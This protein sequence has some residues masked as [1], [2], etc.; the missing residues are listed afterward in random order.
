MYLLETSPMAYIFGFVDCRYSS[1]FMPFLSYSTQALS[2]FKS[3]FADL[4]VAK[5]IFCAVMICLFT[6]KEIFSSVCETF[7]NEALLINSIPSFF[8]WFSRISLNSSSFCFSMPWLL[9]IKVTLLPSLLNAVAISIP[10]APVPTTMSEVGILSCKNMFSLVRYSIFPM[11]CIFGRLGAEPVAMINL[12]AKY[13]LS[14]T[15]ISFAD[16]NLALPSMMLTPAFSKI[17]GVS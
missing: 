9:E 8:N 15:V 2:K 12:S 17:S 11:S 5:S 1:T 14:P 7:F 4:P 16:L 10:I 13:V 6:C 3:T